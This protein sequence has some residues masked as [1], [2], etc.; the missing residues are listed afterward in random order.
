MISFVSFYL[1]GKKMNYSK[2]LK[3]RVK[4]TFVMKTFHMIPH[5][6]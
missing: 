2:L 5:N 6:W 1:T 4:L 3:I